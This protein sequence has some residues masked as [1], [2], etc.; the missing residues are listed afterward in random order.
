MSIGW[1]YFLPEA[2]YLTAM[3]AKEDDAFLRLVCNELFGDEL[4][5]STLTGHSSN[6]STDKTPKN[7]LN[8]ETVLAV[9]GMFFFT[10]IQFN[11][12]LQYEK[13]DSFCVKI[14]FTMKF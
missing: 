10:K 4:K 6:R 5:T 3:T 11:Q 14:I 8:P 2:I 1:G 7:K 9:Q 12:L 13:L